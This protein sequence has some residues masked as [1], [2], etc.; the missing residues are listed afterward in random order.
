MRIKTKR[1][2]RISIHAPRA[3][4]DKFAE[5]TADKTT[6][7]QSTLPVRGATTWENINTSRK[8]YFN[9]RSPCGERLSATNRGGT[10]VEFQSTL[11]V[12]GAT[13]G[14]MPRQ[15]KGDISIHAPRAGSDRLN[16]LQMA[17]EENF[18]PRSPCGERRFRIN[19]GA[20]DEKFQSTL[21]VRGATPTIRGGMS[22]V[23]ISIHA[24]RAGSDRCY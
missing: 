6:I 22:A 1:R 3:G 7:F 11:P 16:G 23:R 15:Q 4:S 12:R 10:D 24:P 19:W 5:P 9:P 17:R 18:N 14:L 13:R 20:S 2:V 21:P 8:E